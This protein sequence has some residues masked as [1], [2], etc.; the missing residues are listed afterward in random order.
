[1][2]TSDAKLHID[3]YISI[4]VNAFPDK[5]EQ[6][7]IEIQGK[8]INEFLK[9][10]LTIT[11]NTTDYKNFDVIREFIRP[12]RANNEIEMEHDSEFFLMLFKHP[13]FYDGK[14]YRITIN[15]SIHE[16]VFKSFDDHYRL[17]SK[18]AKYEFNR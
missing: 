2:I 8:V 7:D 18:S 15:L 11:D 6:V 16:E 3:P 4:E 10:C 5:T 9:R 1:M 13:C 17:V 12:G 14:E